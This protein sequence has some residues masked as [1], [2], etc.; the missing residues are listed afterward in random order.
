VTLRLVDGNGRLAEYG[1]GPG[2][3]VERWYHQGDNYLEKRYVHGACTVVRLNLDAG[4]LI[5]AKGG[6]ESLSLLSR[7]EF[8]HKAPGTAPQ[9]QKGNELPRDDQRDSPRAAADRTKTYARRRADF[10]RCYGELLRRYGQT[11]EELDIEF[12]RT[13]GRWPE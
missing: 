4:W 7:N 11:W 9:V 1:S 8:W 2:N 5:A 13:G 10:V 6:A 12:L 3:R